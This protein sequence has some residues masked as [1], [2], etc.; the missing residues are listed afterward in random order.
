MN[1]DCPREPVIGEN[2]TSPSGR[3]PGLFETCYVS[4]NYDC[5][6]EPVIGENIT[7]LPGRVPGLIWGNYERVVHIEPKVTDSDQNGEHL[8]CFRPTSMPKKQLKRLNNAEPDQNIKLCLQKNIHNYLRGILKS[9]QNEEMSEVREMMS[10]MRLGST[11]PEEIDTLISR[12]MSKLWVPKDEKLP[13]TKQSLL[14]WREEDD[15]IAFWK[16][17]I[18]KAIK[19]KENE[20]NSKSY[21]KRIVN[22]NDKGKRKRSKRGGGWLRPH[23]GKGEK[24]EIKGE[25]VSSIYKVPTV[26]E[27]G[28]ENRQEVISGRDRIAR[29]SSVGERELPGGHQ[30]GRENRQEVISGGERIARRSSVGERESTG[31][32]LWGRENRQQVISGGAHMGE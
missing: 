11:E 21:C 15:N 17:M 29:R 31:G 5:P 28:R 23:C 16:E 6:R 10:D 24:D 19:C 25:I 14:L 13:A 22:S 18:V 7:S 32:H 4:M 20:E 3:V 30:W 2:I 9:E 1:Y 27:C 8:Q 26:E 12:E